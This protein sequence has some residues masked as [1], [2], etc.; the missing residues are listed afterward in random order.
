MHVRMHLQGRLQAELGRLS[1]ED[2][3]A[4]AAHEEV[5]R[6]AA[7]AKRVEAEAAAAAAAQAKAAAAAAAAAEKAAFQA[8]IEEKRQANGEI[9][10]SKGEILA[11][12]NA[13]AEPPP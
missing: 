9:A 11:E 4:T 6:A 7:E 10:K 1:D 5:Q 8:K 3:A 2:A 12:L 13:T